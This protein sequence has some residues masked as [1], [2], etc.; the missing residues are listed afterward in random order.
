M[1]V[2]SIITEFVLL[3]GWHDLVVGCMTEANR[4]VVSHSVSHWYLIHRNC[5]G[6]YN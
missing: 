4:P 6:E 1:I 2:T 3:V 5:F